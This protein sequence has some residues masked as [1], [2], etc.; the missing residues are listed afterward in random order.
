MI[1]GKHFFAQ[2]AREAKATKARVMSK[3][4]LLDTHAYNQTYNGGC[5]ELLKWYRDRVGD[6]MSD[7]Q[8]DDID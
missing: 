2:I 5:A 6:K 1:R 7:I 3:V 4:A 8:I